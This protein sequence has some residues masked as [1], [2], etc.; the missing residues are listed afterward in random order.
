MISPG[1]QRGDLRVNF[2]TGTGTFL[3]G[4]REIL[5]TGIGGVDEAIALDVN[6]D[7]FDDLCLAG[8]FRGVL[9]LLIADGQ[10]GFLPQR[11]L[12]A[13]DRSNGLIA[14]DLNDDGHMDFALAHAK[15]EATVSI[16]LGPGPLRTQVVETGG[17]IANSIEAADL[18]GDGTL[19]LIV[20]HR[21]SQDVVVL[22]P[23][24]EPGRDWYAPVLRVDLESGTPRDVT[25]AH[26]DGDERID[27]AVALQ[28]G[29][30]LVLL[31]NVTPRR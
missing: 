23:V 19:E 3:P 22:S 8:W 13:D 16:F 11:S 15:D 12:A 7:G 4:T 14:R 1:N 25:A 10:G 17:S 18:D 5:L 2:G 24:A 29:D 20:T 27:L 28:D 30:A 6:D 9:T 26:L 31:R 21:D